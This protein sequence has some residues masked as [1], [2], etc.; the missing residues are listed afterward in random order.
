MA[1]RFPS[2]KEAYSFLLAVFLLGVAVG[3]L[4][5]ALEARHLMKTMPLVVVHY[6]AR[7][8]L[9]EPGVRL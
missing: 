9:D 2:A 3:A 4:S 7:P 8:N 6:C 5:V 1:S